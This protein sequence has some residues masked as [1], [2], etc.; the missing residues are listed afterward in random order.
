VYDECIKY[1]LNATIQNLGAGGHNAVTLTEL[2]IPIR[3]YS[4]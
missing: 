4:T 2:Y 3:L 1:K